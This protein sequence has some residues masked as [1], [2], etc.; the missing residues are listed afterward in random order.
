[1]KLFCIIGTLLFSLFSYWQLNDLDQ[2]GTNLWQGWLFTYALTAL[3]CFISI[4]KKLPTRIYSGGAILA[5]AHAC[6][7]L[8]AIQM[9]RGIFFVPDNPAGNETGGLLIVAVWLGALAFKLK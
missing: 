5:L 3:A 8:L 2:Y 6:L 9:E 4:F 1:M 7:R